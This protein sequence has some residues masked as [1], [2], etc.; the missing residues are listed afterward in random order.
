MYKLPE[1]SKASLRKFRI[2]LSLVSP[3][4][5]GTMLALK[6]KIAFYQSFRY[7]R[8]N[9]FKTNIVKEWQKSAI[10]PEISSYIAASTPKVAKMIETAPKYSFQEYLGLATKQAL[11]ALREGNYGIGA[12]YVFRQKGTEYV[13]G[14]RNGLISRADTHLHA[15]QDAIDAIESLARGET[16]YADRILSKREAP[17]EDTEKLL[18]TSLEPCPMCCARILTHKLDIVYIGSPDELGGAMLG[19]R[20]MGLPPL[21]I[22]LS[23]EERLQV[24]TPNTD[25]P[26]SP[27]YVNQEHLGLPLEIFLSTR[28]HI[29]AIM[30]TKGLAD[31]HTLPKTIDTLID[32][33]PNCV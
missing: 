25:D 30:R 19:G 10:F 20:E 23:R 6:L 18:V 3:F 8:S 12:V 22:N 31:I 24:V 7:N 9:K 4:K 26:T 21:W 28:E 32:A 29:D 14:G 16:T 33:I 13:I 2:F 17:H 27:A 15:E 1:Y 11:T 5:Y